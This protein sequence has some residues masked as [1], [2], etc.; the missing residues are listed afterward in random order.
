MTSTLLVL[1]LIIAVALLF[2]VINGF[3]DAANSIAT[4]V[5]TRVLSPSIAVLWAAFFNFFAIFVFAPRVA[6]TVARIVRIAP[7]EADYVWVIFCGLI[8]AII[9][10]LLTWW[11][12]LPTSSS[13]A[14]IGGLSGAGLAYAGFDA[15][16]YDLLFTTIQFIVLSPLIGFV[17]G[18]CIM[19]A[20]CWI[21][22]RVHPVSIDSLFRRCQLLSAALYSIGHGA[23]DAQKTMGVIMALLL[24][25]GMLQ[26]EHPLSLFD[27]ETSWI[28]L[29]CNL[30]MSFGTALGGW[31][32]VKTMGMRITRLKPVG[33]FSAETAGAFSLF[34]A[35]HFG[36]PVSTTQTIIAAIIGVGTV[37]TKFSNIKWGI[38]ARIVWAWVLT[39][40]ASALIGAACFYVAQ[41][42]GI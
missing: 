33:G 41:F 18:F 3:H 19:L 9:W 7:N 14:L 28:I 36:I 4:V 27:P 12:S 11:L 15:L 42:F 37:T 17:A 26:E 8:G 23:N 13:H 40:P 1:A 6:D 24:A 34:L 32:I 31:R 29:S 20:N 2:D 35:T 30:A 39:L 16:R 25:S 10:D 5:S 21:F 22:R 38:A